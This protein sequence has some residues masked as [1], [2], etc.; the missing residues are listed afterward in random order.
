MRKRQAQSGLFFFIAFIFATVAIAIYSNTFDGP[1]LYDDYQ[2]IPNNKY[3]KIEELSLKNIYQAA[4]KSPARERPVSNLSFA[5]NYYLNGLHTSGYHWFNLVIHVINGFLVFLLVFWTLQLASRGNRADHQVNFTNPVFIGAFFSGLIFICHPVQTQAV[6]YIV[7]RMTSLASLFYFL[8]LVLYIKGRMIEDYS[9]GK[10][11]FAGAFISFI[12]AIGSKQIAATLPV[13]LVLYEWYFFQDLK[14]EW[15]KKHAGWLSIIILVIFG[16]LLLF[17]GENPFERIM[18]DYQH[19]EF[20]MTERLLTESRVIFF[21]ISLILLPL[22][23]RMNLLHDFSISTSVFDPVTTLLSILGILSLLILSILL[24]RKHKIISFCIIWFFTNLLIESSI[25]GLEII[26]EHRL[27]L[28]LFSVSLLTGFIVAMFLSRFEYTVYGLGLIILLLLS[29][30]TF[31]RNE[32]WSD[33][34]V[35]WT[36]I[37]DKNRNNSRAYLNLGL[38]HLNRKEVSHARKNFLMALQL[39]PEYSI[40]NYN[41]ANLYQRERSYEQAIKYYKKAIEIDENFVSARNNLANVYM[42]LGDLDAAFNQFQRAVEITP[43]YPMAHF[44]LANAYILKN[45]NEE[46]CRHYKKVID[47]DSKFNQARVNLER[48]CE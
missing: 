39:D 41:L 3:I 40:A 4:F 14:I 16:L 6:S 20:S 2:D 46:A 13:I 47:L 28:P 30:A 29:I 23:S 42:K 31:Q 43:D 44:N 22:P 37:V 36:D 9:A 38:A 1:F 25:I 48:F 21:Y 17:L 7:Q 5:L 35:L 12:L 45:R 24:A 26:Y 11:Y 18:T 33:K 27:Y 19:R 10:K 32:I 8:T 34:L 15:I